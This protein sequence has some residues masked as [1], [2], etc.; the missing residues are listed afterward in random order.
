MELNGGIKIGHNGLFTFSFATEIHCIYIYTDKVNLK[1][2]K[3][4]HCFCQNG[5]NLLR[6]RLDLNALAGDLVRMYNPKKK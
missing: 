2:F 4:L 6:K 1:L 3:I 5:E